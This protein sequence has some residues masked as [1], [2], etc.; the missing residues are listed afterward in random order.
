MPQSRVS[1]IIYK[2]TEMLFGKTEATEKKERGVKGV[3]Q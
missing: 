3:P 1:V 2:N